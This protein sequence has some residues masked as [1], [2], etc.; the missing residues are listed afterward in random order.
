MPLLPLEFVDC[1]SDSPYFR[2]NLQAHEKELEITSSQIKVLIKQVN[3]LVEKA[4]GMYTPTR[5]LVACVKFLH[6]SHV[7][8][9]F[10]TFHTLLHLTFSTCFIA[11]LSR[12]Q[13]N[14]A[15]TLSNF[16][17]EVIGNE[18]T[19]D[20]IVIGE[21]THTQKKASIVSIMYE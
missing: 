9:Y 7:T 11:D 12:A 20:E 19:D 21:Y 16:T 8:I 5:A 6:P 4:K 13:R 1:L 18:R 15:N 10:V 2:G 17:F 14:L 3:H